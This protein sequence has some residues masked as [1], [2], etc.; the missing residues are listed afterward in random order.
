MPFGIG[1][2]FIETD[3]NGKIINSHTKDLSIGN[4][5]EILTD[6]SL[7]KIEKSNKKIAHCNGYIVRKF[8]K[9]NGAAYFLTP[10]KNNLTSLQRDIVRFLI[11]D[12][13]LI[14]PIWFLMKIHIRRTLR[15]VKENIDTMRHFVNDA[16]HE[17]KT[18][19]AI[20]SGNLQ[21]LRDSPK[22]DYEL[23]DESLK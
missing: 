20:I 13:L 17:L 5:S 12:I 7:E 14:L 15:P 19:L 9:N 4:I 8:E 1:I 3:K 2:E 21:I 11:L 10:E 22:I 18:P 6:D 16:G 23:V